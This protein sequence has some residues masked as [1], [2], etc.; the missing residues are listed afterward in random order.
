MNIAII[1]AGRGGLYFNGIRSEQSTDRYTDVVP[2]SAESS[3]NL[4]FECLP[5]YRH[6]SDRGG[7]V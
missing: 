3:H 2:S 4:S 1:G 7:M 5:E 6:Y